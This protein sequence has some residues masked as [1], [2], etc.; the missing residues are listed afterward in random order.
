MRFYQQL[1]NSTEQERQALVGAEM[2]T[3]SLQGD[4]DLQDYV[5]FLEQAYH[6]VKHTVPLLM[7]VGARI[8]EEKE[9]LRTAVAEY[10]EEE[11]GHQ[12]W[13]LNDIAACGYDKEA[14]RNSKPNFATELMVSYAYDLINRINPVGFF[15][16]V[17]VLEG[18]S[19]SLADLAANKMRE[20]LNLPVRAF[21]YLLSHGS[22]DQE[23]IQFL[24]SLINRFESKTDQELITHSAKAFYLLY[25]NIFDSIRN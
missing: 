13:I 20:K 12:E 15:G 7:S 2:I 19:V 25:K 18:T 4:V 14:V 9:W 22:I 16:M 1:Q 17:L 6:H 3:R 21:S 8:P 11:I 5:N 24:E 10:I 23:H